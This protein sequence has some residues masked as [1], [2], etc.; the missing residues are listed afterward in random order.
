VTEKVLTAQLRGHAASIREFS[1]RPGRDRPVATR[2]A[3]R[4]VGET[5]ASPLRPHGGRFVTWEQA[6]PRPGAHR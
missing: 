1:P 3:V 4:Q 2:P 6:I 5:V